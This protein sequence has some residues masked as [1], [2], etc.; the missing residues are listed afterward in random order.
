MVSGGWGFEVAGGEGEKGGIVGDGSVSAGV[1]A[2][3]E[4]S[5]DQRGADGGTWWWGCCPP[6]FCAEE[7]VDRAGGASARKVP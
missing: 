6:G 1:L 2:E 7:F 3:A 5:R 4:I